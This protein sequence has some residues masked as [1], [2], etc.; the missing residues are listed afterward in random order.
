LLEHSVTF[1]TGNPG[2][3]KTTLAVQFLMAGVDAGEPG[4]YFS[5]AERPEI[6][7]ELAAALGI[8]LR[9]ALAANKIVFVDVPRLHPLGAEL[10]SIVDATIRKQNSRRVV[11]DGATH[12]TAMGWTPEETAKVFY[13]LVVRCKELGVTAF[14]TF[15]SA[16]LWGT[17]HR[18]HVQ[19]ATLADNFIVLE[20]ALRNGKLD[21]TLYVLKA[22]CTPVDNR[23]FRFTIECGGGVRVV[24]TVQTVGPLEEATVQKVE[25][26]D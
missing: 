6:P 21:R 5:L 11:V 10:I 4:V 14:F 19:L 1:L 3:G 2:I 18:E 13:E 16:S 20:Y 7:L 25:R 23:V 17:Q 15:E 22:N 24:E 9:E 12:I 26:N 8:P